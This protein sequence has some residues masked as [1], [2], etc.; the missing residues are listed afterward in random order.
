MA[1]DSELT[2][3]KERISALL[4]EIEDYYGDEIRQA[5]INRELESER[6]V[7]Q[8]MEKL[9][10][11]DRKFVESFNDTFKREAAIKTILH[12]K[13]EYKPRAKKTHSHEEVVRAI[14][15]VEK[16]YQNFNKKQRIAHVAKELSMTPRAVEKHYYKK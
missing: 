1:K 10:L 12:I 6:Y 9:S 3:R 13:G 4:Q 8:F 14:E 2:E 15:K 16:D 5:E 7:N 11:L